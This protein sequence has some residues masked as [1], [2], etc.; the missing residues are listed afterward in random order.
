MNDRR[1]LLGQ[2]F[3]A[4]QQEQLLSTFQP[5]DKDWLLPLA[6]EHNVAATAVLLIGS[7]MRFKTWDE[8]YTDEDTGEPFTFTHAMQAEGR[9][10]DLTPGEHLLLSSLI[11]KKEG[12]ED[13][14]Q[15][16]KMA[17]YRLLR[18]YGGINP[19]ALLL[20]FAESYGMTVAY[21]ELGDLYRFGNEGCGIYVNRKKAREF[22]TLAC[23]DYN[24][25][26]DENDDAPCEYDY[27]LTGNADTLSAVKRLIDDLCQ[28]F[29]TP[30][31]ELGLFVPLGMVMRVLVGT[32]DYRGNILSM[33]GPSPVGEGQ[34]EA[35]LTLHVEANE[36]SSLFYALRQCFEN[37]KV[38][39]N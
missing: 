19:T 1:A 25:A 30:D 14:D 29:G 3:F 9:V 23:T 36:G 24:P 12:W 20:M 18:T 13:Y 16:Q 11:I 10:F 39:M 28:Q 5:E 27:T 4:E 22:Y 38:E 33:E 32:S 31:N 26:E 17:A 8:E 15:E 37:L 7:N 21:A 35:S 34:E 2:L 6:R